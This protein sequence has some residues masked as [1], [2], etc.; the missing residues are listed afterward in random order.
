M[1]LSQNYFTLFNLPQQFTI[2]KRQL[3]ANFRQLQREVHPDRHAGKGKHQQLLA[4]RFASYVNTA[5]QT[6]KSP[7]LRAEYLL[8]L[9]QAPVNTQTIT[10][11]DSE[12]LLQ[13][14]Q[15]RG[16]L[17]EANKLQCKQ[18]LKELLQT[19]STYRQKLLS[20]FAHAYDSKDF[21]SAKEAIAKL[22]FVEKMMIEIERVE[23]LDNL[24]DDKLAS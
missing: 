3:A 1:D 11:A 9:V 5:Y 17:A 13:Q 7:L 4:M 23:C 22:S 8:E 20:A 16:T 24:D 6:L 10:V 2:D 12:F 15:W 14:M 21:D 19:V 18:T